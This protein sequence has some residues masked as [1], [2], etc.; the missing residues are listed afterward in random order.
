MC[1]LNQILGSE[2]DLFVFIHSLKQFGGHLDPLRFGE[3]VLDFLLV[4]KVELLRHWVSSTGQEREVV[5]DA[6]KY[7]YPVH[8]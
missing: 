1:L 2:L 4:D 3:Q 5:M 6:F 7:F 8:Q